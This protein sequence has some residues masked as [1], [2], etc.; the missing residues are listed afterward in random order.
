MGREWNVCL[1]EIPD[2]CSGLNICHEI[3]HADTEGFGD[4][5]QR[6]NRYIRFTTLN[7]TDVIG[8]KVGKLGEF[9]VRQTG[10]FAIQSNRVA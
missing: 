7:L 6:V 9:F 8:M 1:W 5:Y 4:S 10:R 3:A 2:N